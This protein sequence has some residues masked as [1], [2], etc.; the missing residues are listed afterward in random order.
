MFLPIFTL[1]VGGRERA[2]ERARE[3]PAIYMVLPFPNIFRRFHFALFEQFQQL[4]YFFLVLLLLYENV[5]SN[6]EMTVAVGQPSS[7]TCFTL[8]NK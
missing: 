8:M 6:K 3:K 1:V 4:P 5:Q 2:R 7:C